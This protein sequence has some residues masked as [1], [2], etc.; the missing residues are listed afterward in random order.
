M[1]EVDEKIQQALIKFRQDR[2]RGAVLEALDQT[3]PA[4]LA[5][6]DPGMLGIMAY[7]TLPAAELFGYAP[8]HLLGHHVNI[9]LP[10]RFRTIH[11][12]HLA[13][14][15]AKPETKTMGARGGLWGQT[16]TG[17]EFPLVIG[18]CPLVVLDQNCVAATFVRQ[19]EK[20]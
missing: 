2:Y 1:G 17:A 15:A 14:Y 5:L 12:Q 6:L 13:D 9:L 19:K 18:L 7:A 10:E 4:I 8:D 11:L 16:L 20:G 3:V